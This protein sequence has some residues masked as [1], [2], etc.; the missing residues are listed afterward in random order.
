[1]FPDRHGATRGLFSTVQKALLSCIND[2][3]LGTTP[4]PKKSHRVDSRRVDWSLRSPDLLILEH[5]AVPACVIKQDPPNASD[6]KL[7]MYGL[8]PHATVNLTEK[9]NNTVPSDLQ[10]RPLG[11]VNW[12][13]YKSV[14]DFGF[15]KP[16]A[17][18]CFD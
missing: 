2:L 6:T 4:P 5:E 7:K 8:P 10:Q 15:S 12:H 9:E 17:L 3:V 1:M 14:H 18:A 16:S 13:Y 11:Q